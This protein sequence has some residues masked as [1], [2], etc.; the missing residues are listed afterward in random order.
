[1]GILNTIL[2]KNLVEKKKKVLEEKPISELEYEDF[3]HGAIFWRIEEIHKLETEILGLQRLYEKKE[4]CKRHSV[5]IKYFA[6]EDGVAYFQ[7]R[8]TTI[9]F[10]PDKILKTNFS[11]K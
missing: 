10:N 5:V 1:M 2:D 11:I 8:E 3:V 6:R 7:P 9:G 4:R